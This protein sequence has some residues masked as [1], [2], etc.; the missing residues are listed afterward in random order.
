MK[1]ETARPRAMI[2]ARGVIIVKGFDFF[3][4]NRDVANLILV[5][6]IF[7]P[8]NKKASVIRTLTRN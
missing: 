4:Y 7:S 1:D 2:E 3:G 8:P 5:K 6:T